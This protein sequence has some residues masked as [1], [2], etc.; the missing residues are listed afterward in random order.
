MAACLIFISWF[1]INGC[2]GPL[3]VSFP[4]DVSK[5]GSIVN[6]E[7]RVRDYRSYYF[8]IRF[9]YVVTN[10]A[11]VQRDMALIG[12]G[13]RQIRGIPK[14]RGIVIPVKIKLTRVA[15]DNSPQ[16]LIYENI[17]DTDNRYAGKR[18]SRFRKITTVDL[19][20]GVYRVVAET[21]KDRPEFS[22]MTTYLHI[23]PHPGIKFLPNTVNRDQSRH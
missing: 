17:I 22:F 7:F 19:K 15:T 13:G 21:L 1:A 6:E 12:D 11:E 5:R 16:E 3:V 23:G 2:A 9:D 10:E 14:P 4:F 20:P 8:A 18:E